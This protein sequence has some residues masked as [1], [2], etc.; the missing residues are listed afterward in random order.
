[1]GDRHALLERIHRVH[2]ATQYCGVPQ[3]RAIC[4]TCETLIKNNVA[5]LDPALDEFDAAIERLLT[6]LSDETGA[7]S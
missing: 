5:Q 3:L 1:Q 6:Q 2:G 7:S 4:K